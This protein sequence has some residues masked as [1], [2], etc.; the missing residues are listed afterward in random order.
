M[1][2]DYK[3]G[4]LLLVDYIKS[5]SNNIYLENTTIIPVKSKNVGKN[6]DIIESS[7]ITKKQ[8][9]N[10]IT[11]VSTFDGTIPKPTYTYEYNGNKNELWTG[12][13]ILSYILP[14]NINLN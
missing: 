7:V 3:S 13:Q 6:T 10:I 9:M 5:K 8:L 2:H 1:I 14:K 12:N 4:L 11:N